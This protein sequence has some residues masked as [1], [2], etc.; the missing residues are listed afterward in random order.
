MLRMFVPGLQLHLAQHIPILGVGGRGVGQVAACAGK[1][2]CE[3]EE[4]GART[5]CP[6]P[7]SQLQP[8]DPAYHKIMWFIS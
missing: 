4:H 5:A 6:N 1:G 3:G 8:R 2:E 7:V